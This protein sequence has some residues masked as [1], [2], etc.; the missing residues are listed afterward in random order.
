MARTRRE[1]ENRTAEQARGLKDS[2]PG[3]ARPHDDQIAR[4]A[5]E[6]FEQRGR[7]HG[8]D[9]EDWLEAER[10]LGSRQGE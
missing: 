6:R 1:N 4:R 8:R 3:A 9:L 5:Y 2:A 10:E 7:E